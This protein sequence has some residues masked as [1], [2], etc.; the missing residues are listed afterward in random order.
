MTLKEHLLERLKIHLV[1]YI[2]MNIMKYL[3][4]EITCKVVFLCSVFD[5]YFPSG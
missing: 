5:L 1:K 4:G 2:A 3:D